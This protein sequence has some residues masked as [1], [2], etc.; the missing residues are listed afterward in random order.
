MAKKK[1]LNI[2]DLN[3]SKKNVFTTKTPEETRNLGMAFASSL[4]SGDIIFLKG[5]LG[6]GKTTFTQGVVKAFGNKGFARSSSFMLVNE[7]KAPNNL[8]LFHLD[9]YRLEPSSV[10]DIGIEEY[11]Y[12]DNI[13]LIEWADRL[14][15]AKK[16]NCWNV[17][18]ENS[19]TERKII[20][21]NVA[22]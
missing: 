20:I 14:I 10:W 17:E 16:D 18:I 15:G 5:N 22:K 1:K 12:S 13:S 7:Y 11:I 4:K 3:I 19:G 6:S 8:K 9:L 2:W 21:E